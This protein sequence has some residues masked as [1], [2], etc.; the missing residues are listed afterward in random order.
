MVAVTQ[1]FQAA[2]LP[3]AHCLKK[4]TLSIGGKGILGKE[5][6]KENL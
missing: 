3:K 1:R 2:G 4:P 5:K 6:A